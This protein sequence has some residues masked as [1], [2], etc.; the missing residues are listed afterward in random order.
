[1]NI[2]FTQIDKTNF[3]C[4]DIGGNVYYGQLK[5][6]HCES[7][8]VRDSLD[9]VVP[10]KESGEPTA[11]EIEEEKAKY[12]ERVRHGVGIQLFGKTSGNLVC[13][14]AGE[15]DRNQIT[16]NGHYIYPNGSEYKGDFVKG[17]FHGKGEYTWEPEASEGYENKHMYKGLWENGAMNGKGE[18]HHAA[19]HICKGYFVNNLFEFAKGGK[20]YFVNPM[21]DKQQH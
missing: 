19:G 11:E 10:V 6:M 8:D 18:F 13:K 5:W 21:E 20:R 7:G 17:V 9:D 15:W 3:E 14:Y 1:M 16:G 12:K 2:D 4:L